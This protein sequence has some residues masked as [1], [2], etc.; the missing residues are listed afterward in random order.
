MN[1]SVI[2]TIQRVHDEY[3]SEGWTKHH[4]Q[5]LEYEETNAENPKQSI[6]FEVTEPA[7]AMEK[8]WKVTAISIVH[9]S[10]ILA[11]SFC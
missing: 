5:M 2:L 9:V 1:G 8:N 6:T 11:C 4:T 7:D 3:T 10:Y